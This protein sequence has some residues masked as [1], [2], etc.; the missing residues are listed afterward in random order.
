M[1]K[2]IGPRWAPLLLIGMCSVLFCCP[3]ALGEIL[4]AV[5]DNAVA[6][7]TIDAALSLEYASQVAESQAAA[8]LSGT[9]LLD[10]DDQTS[11]L[12]AQYVD[13][14]IDPMDFSILVPPWEVTGTLEIEIPPYYVEI[15][16]TYVDPVNGF[17]TTL[18]RIWEA[19]CTISAYIAGIPIVEDYEGYLWFDALG[20][21]GT[22]LEIGDTD[23]DG[24]KEYESAFHFPV[25]FSMELG[26]IPLIGETTATVDAEFDIGFIAEPPPPDSYEPDDSQNEATPLSPDELQ[27]H[28]IH[29]RGD[30]DWMAV[31]VLEKHEYEV[32][33]FNVSGLNGYL[34]L[35]IY[36]DK[37]SWVTYGWYGEP[38]S[39]TAE[40]TGTYYVR[41]T[42]YDYY[43]GPGLCN[44]DITF[45]NTATAFILLSPED[46]APFLSPPT[47]AWTPEDYDLFYFAIMYYDMVSGYSNFAVPLVD[48]SYE[49]PSSLWDA[50]AT[51][52][53]SYWYVVGI[54]TVSGQMDIAGP[55]VFWKTIPCSDNDSDGYGDPAS[56]LCTHPER[57]CDDFRA[58]VNP[59]PMEGPEGDA[60]CSD[61]VDNDC[62]GLIDGDDLSCRSLVAFYPFD[63]NANDESG[64]GHDGI[65]N[66]AILAEDRFGNPNSAYLFDGANDYITVASTPDLEMTD[67]ICITAWINCGGGTTNPRIVDHSSDSGYK[68]GTGGTSNSRQIEFQFGYQYISSGEVNTLTCGQWHFIAAT[69]TP[70]EQRIYL[71]GKLVQTGP[72][73]TFAPVYDTDLFIGRKPTWE[74][75]AWGGLLDDIHIYNRALS[76]GAICQLHHDPVA[77]SVAAGNCSDGI[78]NDCDG[79]IDSDPECSSG[80]CVGGAA[81]S[82]YEPSSVHVASYPANDLVYLFLPLGAAVG[83]KI[84]RRRK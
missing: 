83:L 21:S 67:E 18:M 15:L 35:Q 68:L 71:D 9:V 79:S 62:D 4:Y 70:S 74:Y 77:E 43:Y 41:V 75:D 61:L 39:W 20:I 6:S 33:A 16:P 31:S 24:L 38:V 1:N 51:N 57:D 49:L 80:P 13:L 76:G 37:G 82:T 84:W 78:D 66:G 46:G 14:R 2:T 8:N 73:S 72:G 25:S 56:R 60:T 58:D 65:V 7:N 55:K 3:P 11:I 5:T 63:G 19:R 12:R 29:Q 36:D 22:F 54:D 30:E 44:Y 42:P 52:Y 28:T 53:P 64:N 69:A 59:G 10:F 27:S 50:M 26:E 45:R 47:F 23:G 40:Y 34:E 32:E 48:D 81:A 17:F